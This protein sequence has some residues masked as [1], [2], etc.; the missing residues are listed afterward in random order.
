MSFELTE[1]ACRRVVEAGIRSCLKEIAPDAPDVTIT[2]DMPP[3][4]N[5]CADLPPAR[6]L[7]PESAID[8][9]KGIVPDT[10][11]IT[12]SRCWTARL[13]RGLTAGRD[14][15]VRRRQWEA[16]RDPDELYLRRTIAA[17]YLLER[18]RRL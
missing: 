9:L 17:E 15:A 12:M 13:Y 4:P 6:G 8:N 14:S 18:F 7:Q 11:L 3:T 10:L 5:P 2:W 1:A 16:G